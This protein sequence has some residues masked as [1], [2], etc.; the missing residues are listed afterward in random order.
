MP[1]AHKRVP[2]LPAPS[3]VG[4][5]LGAI[6]PPE[7]GPPTLVREAPKGARTIA[8]TVDDGTCADCVARYVDFAEGSGIAITF[9]P[10]GLYRAN[11]EPHAARLRPL[12][13]RGQVQIA[14]HT[15]AH[16]SLVRLSDA[17][18]VDEIE[19]NERWIEDTYGITA[20]PWFRPPFGFRNAH[21]DAV[22][23]DRGYTRILMWNGT[24]GDA[25]A[26][27]SAELLDLANK[28]LKPGTIML[29]HANHPTITEEFD[30]VVA[31]LNDRGLSPITLD[32]M[33]GTSRREGR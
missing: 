8:L 5:Q 22:A 28:Y 23:A 12:I 29:G 9:S 31:I 21:T 17:Q 30:R 13:A 19:H 4:F 11:W 16:K 26:V 20:R 25:V 18:I 14:N 1:P 10:N 3:P 32:E 33:F 7:P 24:F 6:P 15:W 2:V 27:S